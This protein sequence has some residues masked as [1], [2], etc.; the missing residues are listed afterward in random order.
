MKPVA[1]IPL[2]ADKRVRQPELNHDFENGIENQCH[3]NQAEFCG[4]KQSGQYERNYEISQLVDDDVKEVPET[5]FQALLLQGT[6]FIQLIK[7]W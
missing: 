1:V 5:P 2:F 7:R 3:R 6:Y 4:G